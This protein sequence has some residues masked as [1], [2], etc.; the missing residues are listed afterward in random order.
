VLQDLG[1][2]RKVGVKDEIERRQVEAPRG[3]VRG[4]EHPRA[5]VAQRL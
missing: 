2:A 5:A 4:H 1:V 3:Y